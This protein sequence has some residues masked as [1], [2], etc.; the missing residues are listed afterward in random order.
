MVNTPGV[1]NHLTK[2]GKSKKL[3]KWIPHELDDNQ[4]S[5]LLIVSSSVLLH[6]QNNQ[7]ISIDMKLKTH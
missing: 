7:K 1:S 2:N 3:E 4:K 5:H 6:N